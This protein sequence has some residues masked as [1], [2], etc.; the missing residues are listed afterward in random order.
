MVAGSILPIAI[1]KNK[2]Y[3]LFG[4]ENELADTP[5][6]SDFGGGVDNGETPFKTALREGAE[7]LT[8][9]LG[10]EKEIEAL[11]KKNGGTYDITHGTYHMHLFLLDYDENL[12]KYYNQN[13]RFLWNRMNKEALEK[14]KLFEKAEI[15]WFSLSDM[16]KHKSEFRNFYQEIVDLL[17]ANSAKIHKFAEKRGKSGKKTRKVRGGQ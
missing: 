16:K 3:F 1:R 7:E 6:F 2:L 11:I 17:L 8:G 4:K 5:G 9:F 13:H 14:T 12:P 10:D 15:R